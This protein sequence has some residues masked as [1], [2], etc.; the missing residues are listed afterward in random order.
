MQQRAGLGREIG[1][2]QLGTI[3]QVQQLGEATERQSGHTVTRAIRCSSA[4]GFQRGPDPDP[5]DKIDEL[6]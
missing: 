4:P 5:V 1:E 6:G 2:T 3:K